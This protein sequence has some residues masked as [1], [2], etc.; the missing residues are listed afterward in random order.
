MIFVLD[1]LKVHAATA[2]LDGGLFS[3]LV[4]RI[5]RQP[6]PDFLK[7]LYL[8]AYPLDFW[9]THAQSIDKA[10]KNIEA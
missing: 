7:L 2:K 8:I 1:M 3:N 6:F 5:D 4:G 9:T 10:Y